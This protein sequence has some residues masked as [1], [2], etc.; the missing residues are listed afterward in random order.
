M[1]PGSSLMPADLP[2]E[3]VAAEIDQPA[4][5]LDEGLQRRPHARRIIFRMGPGDEAAISRD[6]IGTFGIEGLVVDHVIGLAELLQPIRDMEIGIEAPERPL[7][8]HVEDRPQARAVEAAAAVAMHV[9]GREA[10]IAPGHEEEVRGAEGQQRPMGALGRRILI[11]VMAVGIGEICGASRQEG[12][13]RLGLAL[14]RQDEEGDVI[15]ARRPA[16]EPRGID[17]AGEIGGNRPGEARLPAAVVE[18]VLMEMDG[19][20][21]GRGLAPADAAARPSDAP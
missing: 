18:I 7:R 12:D 11:G 8:P 13:G 10:E 3:A 2:I 6:E 16:A 21:I 4:P 15:L 19:G 20:V 14:G 17:A 9:I 5:A 1:T